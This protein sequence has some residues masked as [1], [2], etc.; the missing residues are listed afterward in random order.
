MRVVAMVLTAVLLASPLLAYDTLKGVDSV[1]VM[2]D[3]TEPDYMS[4]SE[5]IALTDRLRTKAE[6]ILR[7]SGIRVLP[8]DTGLSQLS[9]SLFLSVNC[10]G[11]SNGQNTIYYIRARTLEVVKAPRGG[12]VVVPAEAWYKHGELGITPRTGLTG[13]LLDYVETATEEFANA[14]LAANPKPSVPAE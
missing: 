14:L 5:R 1:V 9:F 11:L 7:K 10:L 4:D 2:V 12:G 8:T 3:L 13:Y 6:L